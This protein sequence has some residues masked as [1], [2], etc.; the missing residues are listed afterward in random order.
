M[1]EAFIFE[2][3]RTFSVAHAPDQI[4]AGASSNTRTSH[5]SSSSEHGFARKPSHPAARARSREVWTADSAMTGICCVLRDRFNRAVASHP[6]S[7]G[8][9]RSITITSGWHRVACAIAFKP[10]RRH[11]PAPH[12]CQ[13]LSVDDPRVEIVV[14]DED[15]RPPLGSR[16]P[17]ARAGN[18]RRVQ[19]KIAPVLHPYA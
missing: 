14:N 13:V 5:Q 4:P 16:R 10:S 11:D 3:H 1:T 17:S 2:H 9:N 7:R 18:R 6:S 15:N 8:I 12:P 19:T